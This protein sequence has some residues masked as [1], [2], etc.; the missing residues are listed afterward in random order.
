MSMTPEQ[1][2]ANLATSFC[3]HSSKTVIA[4]YRYQNDCGLCVTDAIRAAVQEETATLREALEGAIRFIELRFKFPEKHD[5][6]KKL[7]KALGTE[8]PQ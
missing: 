1:I 4:N 3:P 8:A 6:V 5:L 2:V 7:K